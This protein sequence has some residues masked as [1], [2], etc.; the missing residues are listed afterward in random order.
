MSPSPLLPGDICIAL[1]R[2][3]VIDYRNV[4]VDYDRHTYIHYSLLKESKETF[5]VPNYDLLFSP[6][7]KT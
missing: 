5:G 4:F 6:S 2:S 3:I 7:S 1:L